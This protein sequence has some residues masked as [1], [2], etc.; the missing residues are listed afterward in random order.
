[1]KITPVNTDLGELMEQ[2]AVDIMFAAVPDNTETVTETIKS[3]QV[4]P[5]ETV[6]GIFIDDVPAGVHLHGSYNNVFTLGADSLK[7]RLV[8]E[9]S[10]ASS[11]DELPASHETQLYLWRAPSELRK[12]ISYTV[13]VL[14]EEKTESTGSD[15]GNSGGSNGRAGTETE[16][17]VVV[18]KEFSKVYTQTIVGNYSIWAQKLREYVYARP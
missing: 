11:W 7:Y 15:T 14:Y 5:S 12:T 8:D 17:P 10:S 13:T 2:Q 3:F 4:T 18:E 16:P 6:Q 9:F 1:M